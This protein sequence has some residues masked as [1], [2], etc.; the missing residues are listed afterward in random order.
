MNLEDIYFDE[1]YAPYR[2][3]HDCDSGEFNW[4]FHGDSNNFYRYGAIPS[5]YPHDN[6]FLFDEYLDQM[7]ISNDLME[8]ELMIING[9]IRGL[10]I[11]N[12]YLMLEELERAE[13]LAFL[14]EDELLHGVYMLDKADNFYPGTPDLDLI[15]APYKVEKIFKSELLNDGLIKKGKD[16]IIEINSKSLIINGEKQTREV[17]KKYKRLLESAD[18]RNLDDG[19]KF[20]F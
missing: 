10:D 5:T 3:W 12:E 1:Q 14:K 8:E 7:D 19:V 11:P 15:Y 9:K 17:H 16:Y 2:E 13:D 6:Y 20:V 18:V 4:Q